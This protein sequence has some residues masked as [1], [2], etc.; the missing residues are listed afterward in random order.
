MSSIELSLSVWKVRILSL[1]TLFVIRGATLILF[2]AGANS[3]VIPKEVLI[4][5][6][7]MSI[8]TG[9]VRVLIRECDADGN[10]RPVGFVGDVETAC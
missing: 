3:T 9:L 7:P 5:S 1:F 10:L 2:C 4:Y 8:R 6:L